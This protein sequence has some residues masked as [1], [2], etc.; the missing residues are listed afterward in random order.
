MKDEPEDRLDDLLD[1]A[2][3]SYHVPPPTPKAEMWQR[4]AAARRQRN[5]TPIRPASPWRMPLAV[6][7]L[8]ALGVA[9]ERITSPDPLTTAPSSTAAAV[10]GT[11]AATPKAGRSSVASQL[12]T[13]AHLSQAESFLTEF[14]TQAPAEDFTAKAKALLNTTRLLL[15]SR[16]LKDV[17]T[18]Q[19]LEDLELVLIQIATLDPQ[20]RREELGFI[21]DGLAQNHLRSRLRNAIPVG[22]AIRL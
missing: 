1:D 20:D 9:I 14:N 6:A 8:L 15:D 21:A 7:A 3:R 4:I 16:R 17:G 5:V 18:R 19:L 22:P 12:V 10:P 2:A 13:T 11:D